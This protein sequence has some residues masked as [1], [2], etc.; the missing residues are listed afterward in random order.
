MEN[1]ILRRKLKI[2]DILRMRKKGEKTRFVFATKKRKLFVKVSTE[3]GFLVILKIYYF[4]F[5]E[6]KIHLRKWTLN[7]VKL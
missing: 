4:F 6:K 3:K 5:G 7:W 2:Y 1:V